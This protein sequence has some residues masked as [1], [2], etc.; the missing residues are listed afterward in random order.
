MKQLFKHLRI[1]IFRGLLA[2]IPLVL[3][4]FVVSFIYF[5]VDDKVAR[6]IQKIIG[7][8]IPG[9]GLFLVLL[10]LY[11]LGLAVSNWMGKQIFKFIERVMEK[12]PL[13]KT[14]YH[15]G[16]QLGNAL[17]L[18]KKQVFRRAVL[19]D[20]FRA[21]LYSI[22]FV[23]GEIMDNRDGVPRLK[24]FVPTAP[25][26]TTGFMII[27]AKNEVRELDWTIEE[28]MNTVVSGGI[29]GPGEIRIPASPLNDREDQ[30]GN[31]S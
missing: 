21:G 27:A 13:V 19:I 22:G 11:I 29:I 7:V 12:I 23:T 1:F 5:A 25:N 3:C 17:S 18:P 6:L 8:R 16:K 10:L 30:K 4:Y 28:A 9:L 2:I 15:L 31:K 24:I 26:P 14:I 20:N